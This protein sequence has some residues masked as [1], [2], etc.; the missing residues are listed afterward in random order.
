MHPAKNGDTTIYADDA[1][2]NPEQNPSCCEQMLLK[3]LLLCNA[4]YEQGQCK[5]QN[6]NSYT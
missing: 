3:V 1:M 2:R 4:F 6:A 5:F